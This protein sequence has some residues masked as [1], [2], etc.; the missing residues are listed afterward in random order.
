MYGLLHQWACTTAQSKLRICIAP[1]CTTK[2]QSLSRRKTPIITLVAADGE[3]RCR[4]GGRKIG[5]EACTRV[6]RNGGLDT[7]QMSS[8]LLGPSLGEVGGV[9]A[10]VRFSSPLPGCHDPAS[11]HPPWLRHSRSCL[12]TSPPPTICR[13]LWFFFYATIMQMYPPSVGD[14][15]QMCVA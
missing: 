6:G 1:P 15:G 13:H 9:Q 7:D 4:R 2:T 5:E 3:A 14:P 8:N 11:A 12:R 10:N